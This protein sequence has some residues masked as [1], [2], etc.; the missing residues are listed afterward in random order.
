MGNRVKVPAE[1]VGTY[2]L[3]LDTGHHLDL[4]DTFYVSSISRNLIS[5]SKLD[6]S[7]YYFKF[8]NECFSLFKQN[9]FIGS[10]ILCDDLYKFKLDNVFAESL[11]TLHHNVGTKRGQT[12]ESS[13]YLWH[14]HLGH[15]SKERI[16]R[17]INNEI[18]PNLDFT[19]L[20]IC[21]D[22]IKGKQTKHTV[23]KK[24]TRSSQLLEIIHTDICG[25]FDVPSFGGEKY[26][27]RFSDDFS[28]YVYI[29]L[30]HEKSQAID[31]LKVFINEVERQLDRKV[32]ILRSNRGGEYYGKYDNNGRCPG[33][34]AKFLESHGICAQYTMAGTPQQNG[35]AERR[36]RTLMNMVR[37]MLINS[38]LPVSLWMYALR[39][40]QYL[41][42]RVPSK[43]VPN[44]PF[45][46]WTG[47]KPNLRHL[48]VWGCQVE[49]RIYNPHEKK[50]DSRTTSGFFIGYLEKSKGYRF[51]C[52]NHSTKIVETGNIRFIENDIISESL[53]PRKVEIL[54]SITSSQVVV[55]IVYYVNNPQEQQINGQISHN[56]V[57]TNEPVT[58]GP[59]KI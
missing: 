51:Y 52:P 33:P 11:L 41:L 40:A 53:K 5:L 19:D 59:Q 39:T 16:K 3:T 13:A 25:S 34:F 24:A 21:V 1:A 2:R 42:N 54:S 48:H 38:S 29:Y 18:L 20:E 47:R 44:T 6:T 8:G 26:F 14:E 35:V 55:P 37:S 30:L 7:S 31:A 4:F 17:L 10:G 32:K 50:L 57:V 9:I 27:K 46:L 22:C 43:S 58:E 23:N 28:R 36:N 45:E 15:I 49:V 12:N 56:D